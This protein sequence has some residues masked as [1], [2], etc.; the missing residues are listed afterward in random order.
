VFN[1]L[2][3]VQERLPPAREAAH[4]GQMEQLLALLAQ[5]GLP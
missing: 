1:S 3:A 2:R 5:A 4:R